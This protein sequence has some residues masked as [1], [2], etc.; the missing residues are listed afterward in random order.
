[1]LKCEKNFDLGR[2][3]FERIVSGIKRAGGQEYKRMRKMGDD[4]KPPD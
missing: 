3:E 2:T 1:M 4:E